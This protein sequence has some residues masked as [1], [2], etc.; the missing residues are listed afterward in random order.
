MN[1]IRTSIVVEAP[2]E[3]VW[4]E[5][6]EISDH[7]EWMADAEAITFTTDQR[8]GAGTAFECVTRVGPIRLLDV[9]EIT[10]WQPEISMGVRHVGLVTGDGRFTLAGAGPGSTLVTWTESL[11]FPWWM[12][13]RLGAWAA[14][15]VLGLIWRGNLRRLKGRIEP[16][17]A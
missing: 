11:S 15:P 16:S 3:A 10:E 17:A 7:V 12:G 1:P 8:S 9:M 2:P 6:A 14:R 5:L 13:G 4:T